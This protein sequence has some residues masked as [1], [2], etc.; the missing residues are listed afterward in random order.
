MSVRVFVRLT[1]VIYRCAV[2]NS[3]CIA[4]RMYQVRANLGLRGEYKLS[5]VEISLNLL[6][7]GSRT[8][9][10][11]HMSSLSCRVPLTD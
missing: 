1:E 2:Q 11:S 5:A 7:L 4:R 9:M 3:V 6:W 8:E 10:I